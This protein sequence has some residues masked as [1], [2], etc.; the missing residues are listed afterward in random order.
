[1]EFNEDSKQLHKEVKG[2]EWRNAKKAG[3]NSFQE[4]LDLSLM[5]FLEKQE[6]PG[7]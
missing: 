5:N 3:N 2:K 7:R 1:M 6:F 4:Y